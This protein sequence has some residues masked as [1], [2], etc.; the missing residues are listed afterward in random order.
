MALIAELKPEHGLA[1]AV[2][3]NLEKHRPELEDRPAQV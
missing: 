1:L 3:E 2:I